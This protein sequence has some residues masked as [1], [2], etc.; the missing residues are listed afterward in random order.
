MVGQGCAL[1]RRKTV[2]SSDSS[3]S[4]AFRFREIESLD[5]TSLELRMVKPKLKVL[6][7]YHELSHVSLLFT[8]L[9]D[10]KN[11]CGYRLLP[12]IRISGSAFTGF[13][14]RDTK[15]APHTKTK[16]KSTLSLAIDP[17]L[18]LLTRDAIFIGNAAVNL[19]NSDGYF[20]SCTGHS[21]L[22]TSSLSQESVRLELSRSSLSYQSASYVDEAS[23]LSEL[24]I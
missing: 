6:L 2:I 1:S 18:W 24:R 13:K 17:S 12:A 22:Q 11:R 19:S 4:L 23:S 3:Y 15:H 5:Y 20:T 9:F 16:T 7:A 14:K 10:L 21:R 8:K